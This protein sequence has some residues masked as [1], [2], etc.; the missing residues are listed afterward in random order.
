M[1]REFGTIGAR[2]GD[3]VVEITTYRADSYDGE[4]RKPTVAFGTSLGR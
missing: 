3:V 1:G 2:R 4:T